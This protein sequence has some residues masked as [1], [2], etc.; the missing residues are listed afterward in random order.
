MKIL[1]LK[2]LKQNEDV[3]QYFDWIPEWTEE[4][5]LSCFKFLALELEPYE[6]FY[7]DK[8]ACL[9]LK[10]SG[11][12]GYKT[13]L[14]EDHFGAEDSGEY[15]PDS[16]ER[17]FTLTSAPEMFKASETS[18]IACFNE[19]IF[20]NVC[21]GMGCGSMHSRFRRMFTCKD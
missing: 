17:K 10:G 3:K 14:P 4:A 15:M 20:N 13:L 1:S 12:V 19:N 5:L 16:Y 2:E 11:K 9:L 7:S 6:F 18:I 8:C 21:F